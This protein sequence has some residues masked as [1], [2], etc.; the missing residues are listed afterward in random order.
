VSRADQRRKQLRWG[1]IG[2]AV[3]VGVVTWIATSGDDGESGEPV[4]ASLGFEAKAVNEE[5][6]GEIAADS[7]HP[8]YWAGPMPDK[9]LEVSESEEGGIQVRYLEAGAASGGD[10]AGTLTIGSYPVTDAAAALEGF[11]ER[12]GTLVR[13]SEDGREIFSSREAPSS[14]YFASPDGALQVEVYDPSP[15]RAMSLALS[16]EVQPVD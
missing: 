7:G 14:A 5:E 9:Q 1:V 4:A 13:E 16:D 3:L 6:L 11:A 15:A 12:P 2:L 10:R 8:V